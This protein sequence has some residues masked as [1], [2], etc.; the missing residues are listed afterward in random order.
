MLKK[1]GV[2]HALQSPLL[3]KKA[4]ARS[5]RRRL[6]V[7]EDGTSWSIMGYEDICLDDL[8]NQGI[9]CNNIDAGDSDE[10]PVCRYI[11]LMEKITF[12]IRIYG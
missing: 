12:G 9:N 4:M 10:I 8:Q 6:Y 2:E 11:S 3:F 5:F 7:S 1:Y